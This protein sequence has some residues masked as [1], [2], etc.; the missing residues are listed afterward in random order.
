M[1]SF[2][3]CL[4]I[5]V[6][7]VMEFHELLVSQFE[8][9]IFLAERFILF[10]ERFCTSI[11]FFSRCFV[12]AQEAVQLHFFFLEMFLSRIKFLSFRHDVYLLYVIKV[13]EWDC[14]PTPFEFDYISM[15]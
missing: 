15:T 3:E 12:R 4:D 7:Q 2:Y 14:V 8:I 5:S 10:L 11:C 1:R 9:F 13:W 6:A